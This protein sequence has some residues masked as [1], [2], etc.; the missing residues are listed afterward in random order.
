MLLSWVL[1]NNLFHWYELFT[2]SALKHGYESENR[3]LYLCDV[4]IHRN[5]DFMLNLIP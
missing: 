4:T 2:D 5:L 3:F 1:T